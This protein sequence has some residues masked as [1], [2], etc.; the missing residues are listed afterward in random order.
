[1]LLKCGLGEDLKFPWTATRSN[2]WILKYNNS[3]YSLERLML[4]LKLQYFG[5]LLWRADSLKKTMMLGKI[6][7]RRRRGWQKMRW[8]DGITNSMDMNFTKLWETV[9]Y[10]EAWC[11]AMNGI[12]KSWTWMSDW[13][14]LI[15]TAHPGRT[16]LESNHLCV[17]LQQ[18]VLVRNTVLTSQHQL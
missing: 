10:G 7:G 8:F 14:E 16:P 11:T 6:E 5:P 13:T 12:A 4:K 2:Q 17:I 9:K 18:E 15:E 3:E 1:M